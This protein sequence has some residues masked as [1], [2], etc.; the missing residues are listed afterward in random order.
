MAQEFQRLDIVR[1]LSGTQF[2]V[3]GYIP[4]RPANPYTGVKVNGQG[5]QYKFGPKHGPMKV[6]EATE[7]HPALLAH[8]RRTGQPSPRAKQTLA[9]LLDAVEQGDLQTAQ[10]LVASCRTLAA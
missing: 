3:T 7:T 4:T 1:T 9:E 5:A 2:I 6:G 10:G 8:A